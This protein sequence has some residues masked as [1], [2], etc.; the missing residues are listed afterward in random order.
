MAILGIDFGQR[1]IGLALSEGFFAEPYGVLKND[2]NFFGKLKT[3]CKNEEIKKIVIGLPEGENRSKVKK[4]AEEVERKIKVPVFLTSEV[5]S[6]KE[7]QEKLIQSGRTK[8]SRRQLIDAAS[9]AVILESY[10]NL[11]NL[12]DRSGKNNV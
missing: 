10:L 7:A 3:I 2:R 12:E 6:T 5:M 4:F 8:K 11:K 9:A 1:K